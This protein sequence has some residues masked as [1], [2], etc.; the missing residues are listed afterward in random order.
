VR[1]LLIGDDI[2]DTDGTL[3]EWLTAFAADAV[4][5]RPDRY[6]FGVA[7]GSL[8]IQVLLDARANALGETRVAV[9]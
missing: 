4:L 7:S 2:Q 5:L 6:V 9:D 1:T 3:G 8:A